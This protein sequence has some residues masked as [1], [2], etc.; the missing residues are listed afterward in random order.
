MIVSKHK[1]KFSSSVVSL[2]VVL[3]VLCQLEAEP[4]PL[5]AQAQT[6]D[7]T[8]FLGKNRKPVSAETHLLQDLSKLNLL[9]EYEK[10]ESYTAPVIQAQRLY[11][12]HSKGDQLYVD[13]LNSESGARLW[14]F[15]HQRKYND[16]YGY[17]SGPRGSVLVDGE[18]VYLHDV[19]GE[20]LCLNKND[21]KKVWSVNTSVF[22]KV[23]QAFFGV[24]S[25]PLIEG[26]LLIVNVGAPNG[27]CVVA[28]D[29]T[30]G[31]EQ[32]VSGNKWLASYASPVAATFNGQRRVL[33][34]AGG[35]TRPPVGGL[36]SIN[37]TDGSIDFEFPWRSSTYE[38]VNA[39]TPVVFDDKVYISATYDTGACLLQIQPDFS[40]KPLWKSEDLSSHWNT[41]IYEEGYLYG[42][43]G[44]HSRTATLV[45]LNVETGKKVW[46][47]RMTWEEQLSGIDKPITFGLQMASLLKVDGNYLCL[48]EL[49]HLLWL[50]LSPQ[51][52]KVLSKCRLFTAKQTWC[53]P[54][55]SQGLL[56][57]SQNEDDK[58]TGKTPRLRCYD[59][60]RNENAN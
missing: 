57:I 4:K 48:S 14:R 2:I 27:P 33:V 1:K 31:R 35:K 8:D 17:G 9:W 56:Y 32:W 19:A 34:F 54:I 15:E 38:S 18:F 22:Y 25:T 11:F 59:M 39:S 23:P 47:E 30:T 13:C 51:G 16:S 41:P 7:V 46:E 12:A 55:I 53:A 24:A 44:R 60:R 58:L 10:S 5:D 36:I 29:K 28:F 40:A 43:N 6:E 26:K 49:G 37:P 52:V 50:G 21:G 45:C 42:I 3:N 20:L